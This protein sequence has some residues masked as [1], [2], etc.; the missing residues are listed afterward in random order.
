MAK[1]RIEN[2]DIRAGCFPKESRMTWENALGLKR[3]EPFNL[4]AGKKT[5][6]IVLCLKVHNRLGGVP[7]RSKKLVL[8]VKRPPPRTQGHETRRVGLGGWGRGA[9]LVVPAAVK[10]K[11]RE[12]CSCAGCPQN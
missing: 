9:E 12:G 4:T 1:L 8:S 5:R 2:A 6:T 7:S 10:G 11:Q 3:K